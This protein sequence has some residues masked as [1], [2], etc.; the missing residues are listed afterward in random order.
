MKSKDATILELQA[1]FDALNVKRDDIQSSTAP[2][3]EEREAIFVK[4]NDLNAKV[5]ILTDKINAINSD[6]DM[7]AISSRLAD[8]A[9]LI[10]ALRKVT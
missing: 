6:G 8:L 3:K 9:N 4:I 5:N 10:T 2:L 1:E 7:M